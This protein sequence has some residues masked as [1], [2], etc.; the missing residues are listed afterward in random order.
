[1]V[2]RGAIQHLPRL[3]AGVWAGPG[4][5][6]LS[7]T[8]E[9]NECSRFLGL[10]YTESRRLRS[11]LQSYVVVS[12]VHDVILCLS[13]HVFPCLTFDYCFPFPCFCI[14]A[15]VPLH[16]RSNVKEKGDKRSPIS[17]VGRLNDGIGAE[18]Y[19]VRALL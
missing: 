4:L 12:C 10:K 7:G 18:T 17:L 5:A 6:G 15:P 13:A 14:A 9:D 16:A 19:S 8:L 2:G 1:M 11:D 3:L